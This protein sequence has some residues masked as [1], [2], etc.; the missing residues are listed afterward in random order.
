MRAMP[1]QPDRDLAADSANANI[2]RHLARMAEAHPA[3]SAVKI[4][5]G[6]TSGGDI[7]YL[8]LTFAELHAEV[9]AWTQRLMDA[10]VR[11]GDRTL[12]MV[13][14]GLPL[15]ASAFAVFQ[16]GAVPVIIDP[17]M[18]LKSFLACVRR[19][20]PRAL[21]GIP[22]AQVVS[23]LFRPSFRSVAVR[24]TASSRL[25]ARLARASCRA[26]SPDPAA[27]GIGETARSGD[28][29][30]HASVR[31]PAA[32]DPALHASATAT[33]LA[34]ILFT[35]GSTGAPKGVCY[36]H[37]MFDAQ[38]RLI[39]RTYDIQPGEI[40]LPLLPIFALFNPA[41]GMTT[42]VPEID[43]RRPA[44]VDPA[45]IV[46]AIRQEKV[47]N[48]FGSPTLWRKIGDHCLAQGIPLPSLR[49]VLCAGAAV[50]AALWKSSKAFLPN[51]CLHS[52]YGAT[53]ALPVA[54]VSANEIDPA[55]VRGACVGRPVA[56]IDVRI[57]AITDTRIATMAEARELPR[58]QIGEIIVRGPVVTK[59]YDGAPEETAKAKIAAQEDKG[60]RP[61]D[62]SNKDRE[63]GTKDEATRT[64]DQAG[65]DDE[66]RRHAALAPS[67]VSLVTSAGATA[68]AV[69]HRMGD[70][71]YLDAEGRLWFC[72]RK[73]ER[74]ETIHGTFYSEP[75]EQVFRAHPRVKRCALIGVGESGR[76]RPALVVEADV[77]DSAAARQFGR[78]LGVLGQ[79]HAHTEL[80]R[81]FYFK[82][83]FPVDVR[84][85]AKIHRLTLA[86]WAATAKGYEIEPRR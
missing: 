76:R 6:R 59:A 82:P 64:K 25:T 56:E 86:R 26:G 2:A 18:G 54:T 52:P 14:Q 32:T 70:C 31:K 33:D 62:P 38:V 49:R 51:G 13:R 50:P 40:D 16:L 22:M 4:P 77:A 85:N 11:R 72:G 23:R 67:H 65:T 83:E 84:H 81:W 73:A 7:D 39:G 9:A 74:V 69:W 71:G 60:P 35:S 29:A 28:P 55:S 44:E 80:I 5:R 57:I 47:T 20:H 19:S 79:L 8:E 43:P 45:K 15:I 24:V 3:R 66:S 30:L 46:Q 34:A 37:G 78:E 63:P 27:C 36:E 12:V 41:L 10:G 17:G 42:I 68:P 53:E 61:E 75:C 48:S 21:V 58:G 1:A